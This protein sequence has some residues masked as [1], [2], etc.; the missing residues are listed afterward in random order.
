MSGRRLVL[1][2]A[3]LLGERDEESEGPCR[4]AS[5]AL[6]SRVLGSL[7]LDPLV[8]GSVVLGSL[9]LGRD[10]CLVRRFFI[11]LLRDAARTMATC[12]TAHGP[13]RSLRSSEAASARTLLAPSKLVPKCADPVTLRHPGG[14]V[15]RDPLAEVTPPRACVLS[16]SETEA[17][18]FQGVVMAQP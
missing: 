7:A 10:P 12:P 4:I 8:L 17:L 6:C 9:V 16:S 13:R 3:Q 15:A 11:A 18:A 5:L 1:E 14:G 2:P